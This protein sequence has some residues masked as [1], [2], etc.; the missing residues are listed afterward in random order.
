MKNLAENLRD[1]V[2]QF[3][4]CAEKEA[5]LF[6]EEVAK[7]A[8]AAALGGK[9]VLVIAPPPW[10]NKVSEVLFI[11]TLNSRLMD[12]N[13]ASPGPRKNHDQRHGRTRKVSLHRGDGANQMPSIWST[14]D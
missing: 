14:L 10:S 2:S 11:K 5:R 9:N 13:I 12:L 7:Q 4:P 6:F 1:L 8:C 3:G